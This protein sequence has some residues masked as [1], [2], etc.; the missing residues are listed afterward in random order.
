MSAEMC[1]GRLKCETLIVSV[2]HSEEMADTNG[3]F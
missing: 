3:K 1:V 2:C